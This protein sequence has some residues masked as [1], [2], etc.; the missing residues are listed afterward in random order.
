MIFLISMYNTYNF[1]MQNLAI[2]LKNTYFVIRNVIKL[3]IN[4]IM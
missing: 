3:K 4:I 2:Y 1:N